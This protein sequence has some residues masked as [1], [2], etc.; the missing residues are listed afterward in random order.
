M[1]SVLEARRSVF[2]GLPNYHHEL[3]CILLFPI[4]KAKV[5]FIII[6]Y[7]FVQ[8]LLLIKTKT[9]ILSLQNTLAW[10][11]QVM[12]KKHPCDI[13]KGVDQLN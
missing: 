10:V 13:L 7:L 2:E 11:S 3:I 12:G 6:I 9:K 5:N 1:Y 4:S 8:C